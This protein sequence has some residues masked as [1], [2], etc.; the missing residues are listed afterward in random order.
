MIC[1]FLEDMAP[2]PPWCFCSQW[3]PIMVSW[4]PVWIRRC[5]LQC[6]V[7][8]N[9]MKLLL[10]AQGKKSFPSCSLQPFH[11]FFIFLIMPLHAPSQESWYLGIQP[12]LG[13]AN[14]NA[15][16]PSTTLHHQSKHRIRIH[17]LPTFNDHSL[18]A[19]HFMFF[20]Y[21]TWSDP[22]WESWCLSSWSE[23]GDVT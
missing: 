4:H 9:K 8:N 12:K 14:V 10:R 22:S 1:S 13:N 5:H 15:T 3:P 20:N 17:I 7:T 23:L 11:V 21:I 6:L 2:F 19:N 18:S 16:L